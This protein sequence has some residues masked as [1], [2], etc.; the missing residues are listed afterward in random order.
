MRKRVEQAWRLPWESLLS[1]TAAR[2]VP[3]SLFELSGTRLTKWSGTS[4]SLGWVSFLSAALFM[5]RPLLSLSL[6]KI[7][8]Q[9]CFVATL[10]PTRHFSSSHFCSKFS[11]LARE[12]FCLL[13]IFR[14]I[15]VRTR[16]KFC[17]LGIFRSITVRNA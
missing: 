11:L 2:T 4:L 12:K 10:S 3:M 9:F 15:T 6:P 13:G 7:H 1:C 16:E 5:R 8:M 17:L 14:S